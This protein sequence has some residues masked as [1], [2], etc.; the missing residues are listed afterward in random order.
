M[1]LG[2][3]FS[4]YLSQLIVNA[5]VEENVG[6]T[7]LSRLHNWPHASLMY[8][9]HASVYPSIFPARRIVGYSTV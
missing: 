5:F 9:D 8:S 2:K 3:D 7:L 4:T 6:L 1:I